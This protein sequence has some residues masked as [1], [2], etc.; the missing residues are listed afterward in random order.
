MDM[1]P[2]FR[3]VMKTCF[4]KATLIADRYHV[5]RQVAWAFELVRKE[6]Q[7]K[8]GEKRRKYFKHSR[9]VLLKNPKRLSEVE[10]DQVSAMLAISERLRFAYALKSEFAKVMESKNS[11]EGRRRLGTWCMMA[12][13]YQ[14]KIPEFNACFT[15]FTNW[16]KEILASFDHPYTNGYTEGVNNKIKV[17]KRNAYG[18]RNFRRFRNRILHVMSA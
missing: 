10:Q 2:L 14:E 17:L 8:F 3:S 5:V 12:Q 6:E 9:K 4:P 7:K 1:S 15:T 13:G 16:Q 11:Y 18:V